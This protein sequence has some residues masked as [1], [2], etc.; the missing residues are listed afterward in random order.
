MYNLQKLGYFSARFWGCLQSI[1]FPF[2]E[3]V[4]LYGI[5]ISPGIAL[6]KFCL[7]QAISLLDKFN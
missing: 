3:K 2:V 5:T 1:T 6:F 7:S 4:F